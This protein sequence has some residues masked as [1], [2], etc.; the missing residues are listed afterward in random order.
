MTAASTAP[1]RSGPPRASLIVPRAAAAIVGLLSLTLLLAGATGPYT[2]SNLE[3]GYDSSYTRTA[4]VV[5]GAPLAY[6]GVGDAGG[7]A[8]AD[9]VER[10]ARLFVTKG[11]VTCHGLEARGSVGPS[12]VGASADAITQRV[13]RGPG[14]MPRYD[15]AG[16]SDDDI[17]AIS[18]YLR[19][20]PA[21]KSSTP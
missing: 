1:A 6:G 13:R 3:A 2:H 21:T 9:A 20:I 10:G 17:A 18:A 19:S 7:A 12:I 5:V 16:L 11:C 14:G 4:Q 15:G 8:A